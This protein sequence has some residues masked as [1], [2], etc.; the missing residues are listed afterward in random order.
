MSTS[1][2]KVK[3]K[4]SKLFNDSGTKVTGWKA[5]L[6]DI[7]RDIGKLQQFGS[8]VEQKIERG[9]PWPGECATPLQRQPERHRDDGQRAI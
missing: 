3:K 1:I 9:E 6:A 8:I 4:A 7:Q 2:T 5:V